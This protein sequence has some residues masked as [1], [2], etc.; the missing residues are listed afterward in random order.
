MSWL[1]R[2][3]DKNTWK[4]DPARLKVRDPALR[5]ALLGALG[6][7]GA[8]AREAIGAFE[9]AIAERIAQATGVSA[10]TVAGWMRDQGK[11]AEGVDAL[12]AKARRAVT[13]GR[14]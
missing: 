13:E 7:E 9:A 4:I 2:L 8:V 6:E 11:L 5:D 10:E 1:S 14:F 12:V 3:F